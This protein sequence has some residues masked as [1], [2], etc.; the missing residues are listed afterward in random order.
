MNT[1]L[2]TRE[3]TLHHLLC[4]LNQ[5]VVPYY[6]APYGHLGIHIPASLDPHHVPRGSLTFDYTEQHASTPPS[7]SITHHFTPYHPFI[8]LRYAHL[9]AVRTRPTTITMIPFRHDGHVPLLAKHELLTI[10]AHIHPFLLLL[11]CPYDSF[12]CPRRHVRPLCLAAIFFL[13]CCPSL[14]CW[15]LLSRYAASLLH[16]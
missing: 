9:H 14:S 11:P 15:P 8:N 10:T 3:H 4:K 5:M 16:P 6:Q 2:S 13:S 12:P 1:L 7:L